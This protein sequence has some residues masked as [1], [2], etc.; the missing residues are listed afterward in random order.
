VAQRAELAFWLV[1]GIALRRAGG[2]S[3][4]QLITAF[5]FRVT[6][7]AFDPFPFDL[8]LTERGIQALPEIDIFNRFFVSGFPA[9]FFQL[10]IHWVIP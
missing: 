7:V 10:W 9:A 8:M 4:C 2:G 5:I 6:G 1:A 3:A